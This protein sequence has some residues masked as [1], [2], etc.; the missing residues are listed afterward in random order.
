MLDSAKQSWSTTVNQ[1][2]PKHL[3]SWARKMLSP[4]RASSFH[5]SIS[6]PSYRNEGSRSG[7]SHC[8]GVLLPE[9]QANDWGAAAARS[10]LVA[11]ELLGQLA[12]CTVCSV[13]PSS[14]GT[15][16]Q[17]NWSGVLSVTKCDKLFWP[18]KNISSY[19]T[20][21]SQLPQAIICTYYRKHV[22]FEWDGPEMAMNQLL[23]ICWELL[24]VKC[25]P[26]DH[27]VHS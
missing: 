6:Q 13:I 17:T 25:Q 3:H 4:N 7:F 16:K 9:S 5:F 15:P 22:L 10:S 11:S 20:T 12:V 1:S 21:F 26:A 14:C 2:G 27:N 23:Q 19:S 24:V 18:R 8:L